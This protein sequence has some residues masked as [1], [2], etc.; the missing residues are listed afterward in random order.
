MPDFC[1]RKADGIEF[2]F[3]AWQHP[4][5]QFFQGLFDYG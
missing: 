3:L 1:R 2:G 5:V 4:V